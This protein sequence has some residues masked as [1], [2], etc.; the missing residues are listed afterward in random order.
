MFKSL[1]EWLRASLRE[2]PGF[3]KWFVSLLLGGLTIF[4]SISTCSDIGNNES[5]IDVYIDVFW[6]REDR[7]GLDSYGRRVDFEISVLLEERRWKY[8]SWEYL[9]I[10]LARDSIPMYLDGLSLFENAKG[11]IVVG[12]ASQEG[13]RDDEVNR[14]R[15]RADTLGEIVRRM[16]GSNQELFKLILGQHDFVHNSTDTAFQRRVII[17]G[18]MSS[19]S[20]MSTRD[21]KDALRDA[22]KK[23]GEYSFSTDQYSTFDFYKS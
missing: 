3:F 5:K 8:S 23:E 15:R 6:G 1:V 11:V 17:I 14:A 13:E 2:V 20:T 18:I 12:A 19:D 7:F 16:L 22:L 4:V 21:I 9:E 10:G